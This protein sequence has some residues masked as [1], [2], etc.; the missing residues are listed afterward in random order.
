MTGKKKNPTTKKQH[1]NTSQKHNTKKT[2][3]KKNKQTKTNIDF[4]KQC[5][6]LEK[7]VFPGVPSVFLSTL[8]AYKVAKRP[9]NSGIRVIKR[10]V[11][12]IVAFELA[13]NLFY[14]TMA[15]RLVLFFVLIYRPLIEL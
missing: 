14:P 7:D 10:L 3:R 15:E 4:R 5:K 2:K 13:L 6:D 9:G 1:E 11:Y 8:F 12:P